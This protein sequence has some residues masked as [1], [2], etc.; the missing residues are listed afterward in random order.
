MARPLPLPLASLRA[1]PGRART[2]PGQDAHAAA[3]PVRLHRQR[4]YDVIY[5]YIFFPVR[6]IWGST[7]SVS[8]PLCY[9]NYSSVVCLFRCKQPSSDSVRVRKDGGDEPKCCAH[10]ARVLASTPQNHAV[11]AAMVAFTVTSCSRH[12][13]CR[14]KS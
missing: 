2:P 7:Y 9:Q 12:F 13:F 8:I 11:A 14:L 5:I 1:R 3:Q 10:A 4:R 6:G